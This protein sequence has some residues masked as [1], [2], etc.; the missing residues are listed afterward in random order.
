[1]KKTN[2]KVKAQAQAAVP[3]TREEVAEAIAG[4]GRAQRERERIQAAMNDEIAAIKARF[5]AEAEPHADAIRALR[6][7]V[8][9]WCEANRDA[10]TQGGRIKTAGFTSGEVRWR[11]TPP[12]VAVR[13]AEV[14]LQLL[15]DRGLGR[16]IRIKEE[17][18]KEALLADPDAVGGIPGI[19]FDSREEFVVVPFETALEEVV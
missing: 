17:V 19:K 12:R 4:I 15:R 11:N 2:L 1:M 10:L 7:G 8:Q 5:E 16:F 18:N 6:E 3:Q 13:A 14:V 9:T